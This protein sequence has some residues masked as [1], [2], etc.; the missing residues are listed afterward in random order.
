MPLGRR[1]RRDRHAPVEPLAGPADHRHAALPPQRRDP[2]LRRLA[3]QLVRAPR[4][5]RRS[6]AP[7]ARSASRRAAPVPAATCSRSRPARR[8]S[9][10]STAASTRRGR[11]SSRACS[12]A[13]AS[14]T[15]YG[16]LGRSSRTTSAC[17]T[18]RARSTSTRS[19]GG[20]SARTSRSRR[21]RSGSATRSPTS[22]RRASLAALIYALT[23]RIARA[24]DEGEPLPDPPHRLIEENLW[25]AIRYGLSGELIDLATLGC[26]PR[27][28][29]SRS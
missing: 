3:Q 5:R 12:R 16:E 17:S 29:R 25:R 20:A 22:P 21:S 19:S 8:S 18:R 14:P 6:R 9:R 2:P 4:P 1:A 27:A 23:A 24:V 26:G 13:A 10:T 11:R 7:T 28:P 15:R